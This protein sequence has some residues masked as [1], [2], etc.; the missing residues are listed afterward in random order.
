MSTPKLTLE[1]RLRPFVGP[2]VD[3]FSSS[4]VVS[5]NA[6]ARVAEE[7]A[8]A[9]VAEAIKERDAAY[10]ERNALVAAL[11]KVFPA[12]VEQ[13]D[14]A[15][16]SWDPEWR[17]IIAINIPVLCCLTHGGRQKGPGPHFVVEYKQVTWHIHDHERAMFSHLR[18]R[19]GYVWDG[20]T[21]EEKYARL[22][23]LVVSS[24]QEDS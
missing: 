4:L 6:A 14:P 20:H 10:A 17:T 15:D 22:G 1:Q 5:K 7:H 19:P 12:S 2:A 23:A 3:H 9:E 18:P 24:S 8:Q 13:H 21:K 11:S 16:T